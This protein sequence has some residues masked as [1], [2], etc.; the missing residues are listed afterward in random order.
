MSQSNGTISNETADQNGT[1]NVIDPA[2]PQEKLNGVRSVSSEHV[3]G[4][5][6]PASMKTVPLYGLKVKFD[7]KYP[8]K[9]TQNLRPSIRQSLPLI[10]CMFRYVDCKWG[11]K[12]ILYMC[13]PE[14]VGLP[15]SS[16]HAVNKHCNL[17]IHR[18]ETCL[19]IDR[20]ERY[21]LSAFI[22]VDEISVV[23]TILPCFCC[24]VYYLCT[25]DF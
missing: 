22:S 1:T 3:N 6:S 12:C 18:I 21:A 24:S 16:Y 5:E 4:I 10:P 20:L 9:R 19:F 8:E 11:V 13:E 25:V 2:A 14:W 7:H 23:L 17:S 15:H